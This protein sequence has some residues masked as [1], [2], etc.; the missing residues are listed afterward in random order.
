MINLLWRRLNSVAGLCLELTFNL[1]YSKIYA[2]FQSHENGII[3][4]RDDD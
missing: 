4:M 2:F 3:E 1:Q